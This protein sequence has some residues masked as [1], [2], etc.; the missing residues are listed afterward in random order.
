MRTG[1][2]EYPLMR[3]Q[4]DYFMHRSHTEAIRSIQ[5]PHPAA[6]AVHQELCLLYI[7]RARAALLERRATG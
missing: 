4:A 7:G 1:P 6:A 2:A 3:T 5:S